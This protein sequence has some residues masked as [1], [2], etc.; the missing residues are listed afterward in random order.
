MDTEAKIAMFAKLYV[1]NITIYS[2]SYEY[3]GRGSKWGN[4]FIMGKDGDRTDV[5]RK[6]YFYLRDNVELRSQLEEL[7]GKQLGC[8]CAPKACHGEVLC[9]FLY[10]GKW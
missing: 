1:R 8:Y 10:I 5:I 6:Y 3:I 9:Y 7:R 2:G 4:P